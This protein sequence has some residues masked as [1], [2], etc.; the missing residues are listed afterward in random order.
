MRTR[1]LADLAWVPADRVLGSRMLS[2]FVVLAPTTTVALII[3][4]RAGVVSMAENMA[5]IVATGIVLH[6]LIIVGRWY[7]DVKPPDPRLRS[8]D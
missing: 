6:A 4:F 2:N 8:K 5:S 1:D 7:R 3:F